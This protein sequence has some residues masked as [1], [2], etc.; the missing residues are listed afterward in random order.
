MLGSLCFQGISPACFGARQYGGYGVRDSWHAHADAIS[1]A[2]TVALSFLRSSLCGTAWK[3]IDY[4]YLDNL[5]QRLLTCCYLIVAVNIHRVR[6]GMNSPRRAT[7][8]QSCKES[9]VT[10]LLLRVQVHDGVLPLE[11]HTF[12]AE[13]T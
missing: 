1:E 8:T 2:M 9:A 3:L 7:A 12:S 5:D 13:V 6:V 11:F 4:T 10:R